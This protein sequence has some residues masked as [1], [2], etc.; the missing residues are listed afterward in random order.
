MPTHLEASG[1]GLLYATE[2][3]AIRLLSLHSAKG[4][5]FETVIIIGLEQGNLPHYLALGLADRIEEERRLFYVGL[6]R[7]SRKVYLTSLRQRDGWNRFPS[8]F[9]DELPK[10]FVKKLSTPKK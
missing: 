3:E 5:E 9:L 1:P 8:M 4:L 7:A 10:G 2:E 6:T